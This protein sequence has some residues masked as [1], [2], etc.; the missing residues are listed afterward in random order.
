MSVR[1]RLVDML[2]AVVRILLPTECQKYRT[3]CGCPPRHHDPYTT[4][5]LP[6]TSGPL[7]VEYSAGP[8]STSASCMIT[9]GSE[10]RA[11]VVRRAAPL[12]RFIARRLKRKRGTC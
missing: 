12:P 10:T 5:A 6:S 7:I 3:R 2:E 9:Y 8:Y 4:P 1:L 11:K